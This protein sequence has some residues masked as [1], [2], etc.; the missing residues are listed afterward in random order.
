M[1]TEKKA[2]AI[3]EAAIE[4][5]TEDGYM[6]LSIDDY[7]A[8]VKRAHFELTSEDIERAF[9]KSDTSFWSPVLKS[10]DFYVEGGHVYDNDGNA[11]LT[12]PSFEGGISAS[13]AFKVAFGSLDDCERY[14]SIN[15]LG[16][17]FRPFRHL[18]LG[19]PGDVPARAH[20]FGEEE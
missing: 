3:F 7:H 14:I 16:A 12:L 2:K 20:I 10:G 5:C 4:T 13:L 15:N 8:L 17:Y 1:I 11:V 9:Y 18:R 6:T 19:M